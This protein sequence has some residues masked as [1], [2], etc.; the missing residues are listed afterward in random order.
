MILKVM[1]DIKS[2]AYVVYTKLSI[3][4]L[5][6]YFMCP[7]THVSKYSCIQVLHSYPLLKSAYITSY[8][9]FR[10]AANLGDLFHCH[11]D[12]NYIHQFFLYYNIQAMKSTFILSCAVTAPI[13][14]ASFANVTVVT[15]DITMSGY[16]TY[17]SEP[18][19]FTLTTCGVDKCAEK[20]ITVTD[21]ATI[22]VTEPCVIPTT[23]TK[24]HRKTS[25]SSASAN[26]TANIK[27]TASESTYDNGAMMYTS[28]IFVLFAAVA[29]LL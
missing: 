11:K 23:Y 1:Y 17:I 6:K 5:S 27:P 29:A 20:V 13:V 22:T 26:V 9:I 16:T 8:F 4:Y 2:N 15:S 12:V 3:E 7:S 18:T 19:T 28:G 14:S 10:I 21:P 25:K 24:V